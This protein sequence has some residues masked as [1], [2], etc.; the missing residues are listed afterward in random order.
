MK[1]RGPGLHLMMSQLL[2]GCRRRLS[3]GTRKLRVDSDFSI[4]LVL[5]RR[6]KI[7]RRL[8]VCWKKA[9]QQK[10]AFAQFHLGSMYWVGEGVLQDMSRG[11]DYLLKAAERGNANAMRSLGFAYQ[12]GR[13]VPIDLTQAY[14]WFRFC[15]CGGR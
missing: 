14:R 10:D 2:D 9:A 7:F 6:P 4:K 11:V 12:Q 13:G 3:E 8:S 15:G 5:P 1:G